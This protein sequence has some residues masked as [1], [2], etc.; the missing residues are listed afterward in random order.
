MWNDLKLYLPTLMSGTA[1]DERGQT[2]V[3][4]ALIVALVAS[5][6]VG[7]LFLF[8]GDIAGFFA[9]VPNAL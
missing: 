2:L 3:E 6:L 5:A 4:Y 1:Q 7:A 8:S 9:Q